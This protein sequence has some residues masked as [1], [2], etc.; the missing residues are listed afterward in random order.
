MPFVSRAPHRFTTS[1]RG[2]CARKQIRSMRAGCGR[3]GGRKR[4]EP[5]C[6]RGT[7]GLW[8]VWG[9]KP[10]GTCMCEKYVRLPDAL[11]AKSVRN[12]HVVPAYPR[13]AGQTLTYAR[14]KV[15]VCLT[16]ETGH[17][18]YLHICN[19]ESRTSSFARAQ[20]EV[21]TPG[22]GHARAADSLGIGGVLKSHI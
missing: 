5:A 6:V 16:R 20:L 17:A 21:G 19:V 9:R 13:G 4:P 15:G 10:T 18:N 11:L 14:A 22:G 3:S 7:C 1:G 12:W 8:T 2:V